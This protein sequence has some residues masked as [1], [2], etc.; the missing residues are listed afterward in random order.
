MG[1]TKMVSNYLTSTEDSKG[2]ELCVE[3]RPDGYFNATKMCKSSGKAWGHYKENR[4]T[5]EFLKTLSNAEGVPVGVL[6]QSKVTAALQNLLLGV[7]E[8]NRKSVSAREP[9]E[10]R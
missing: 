4:K 10:R 2:R 5:E 9:S 1:T 8:R 3:M 7:V 6:V